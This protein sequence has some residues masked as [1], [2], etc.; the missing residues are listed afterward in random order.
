VGA[1]VVRLR[2]GG[3]TAE[4][5]LNWGVKLLTEWLPPCI[6]WELL[7]GFGPWED[8]TLDSL[9]RCWFVTWVEAICPGS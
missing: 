2:P 9:S 5:L 3:R 4:V 8:I 6:S 7:I 1:D